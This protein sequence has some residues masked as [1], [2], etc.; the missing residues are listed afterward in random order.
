MPGPPIPDLTGDPTDGVI[1]G[2][3]GGVTDPVATNIKPPIL[4][5]NTVPGAIPPTVALQTRWRPESFMNFH[6]DITG[7]GASQKSWALDQAIQIGYQNQTTLETMIA[8]RQAGS[9]T[10]TGSITNIPTGLATVSQVQA[11][12][13]NGN[14]AHNFTLSATPSKL[15]GCI[16]IYVWQPTSAVNNTP[17]AATTAVLVRWVANGSIG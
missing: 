15:P 5:T 6:A 17:I 8:S 2:V 4:Q 14:A 1:R 16:D 10:V 9:A 3:P 7:S 12:I 13:D 11:S